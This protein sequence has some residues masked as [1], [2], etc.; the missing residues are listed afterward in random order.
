MYNL[1]I[2]GTRKGGMKMV[3]RPTVRY[4]DVFKEYVDSVFSTTRLDRNQILRLALFIAAHSKEYKSILKNYKH[5]DVS[6]P[7]PSWTLSEH[8]YWKDQNYI[9]GEKNYVKID[10]N[11]PQKPIVISDKGEIKIIVG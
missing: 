6:L 1:S 3:Y 2:Y 5:A 4:S 8:E 7:H 11:N 9:K 10:G